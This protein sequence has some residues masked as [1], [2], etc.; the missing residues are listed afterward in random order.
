MPGQEIPGDGKSGSDLQP[1][2]SLFE[3]GGFASA[4]P[5]D[6][7]RD[8]LVEKADAKKREN[9]RRDKAVDDLSLSHPGII[10]NRTILAGGQS[11]AG[12]TE[13]L[14]TSWSVAASRF[15][16]ASSPLQCRIFILFGRPGR[17]GKV[18]TLLPL[19]AFA[20][21]SLALTA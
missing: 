12:K 9:Q 18:T 7:G 10:L 8:W 11:M 6:E 14:K 13:P 21:S 5:L 20:W 15:S 19:R 4:G 3:K 17:I 16:M 1:V 2:G